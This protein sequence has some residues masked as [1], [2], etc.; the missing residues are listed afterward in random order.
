MASPFSKKPVP[1]AV[2]REFEARGDGAKLLKWTAQRFPW[3]HVMSMSGACGGD[4]K[5]LGTGPGTTPAL[6]GTNSSKAALK[7]S[8][9]GK[10]LPLTTVKSLD[11]KAQGSLGTTRKATLNFDCS[12]DEQLEELQ[13]CYFI[14]GMDVR[15]QWGWSESCSGETKEP[16]TDILPRAIADCK[17]NTRRRNGN[18][19]DG[20]Q[21]M[22]GNFKYS[23]NDSN[24]WECSIEIISAADQ[25][26]SR[27]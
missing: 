25:S 27:Y 5:I 3:I 2:V 24:V 17:I 19:Y 20:F 11:V 7:K 23:L 18:S 4:Y 15:V 13:K 8:G 10:F 21:G 22:V 16:L 1:S 9:T 12:T 6:L 26:L 14:P